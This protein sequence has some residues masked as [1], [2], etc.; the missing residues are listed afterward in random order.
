M[1]VIA[2]DRDAKVTLAETC[3]DGAAHAVVPSYHTFIMMRPRVMDMVHSF[4]ETGVLPAADAATC[5]DEL[6]S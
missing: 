6:A 3:L 2:G 1:A 4:L 5:A